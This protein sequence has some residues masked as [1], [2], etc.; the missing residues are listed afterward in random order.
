MNKCKKISDKIL[1]VKMHKEPTDPKFKT[2]T[3]LVT[4]RGCKNTKFKQINKS[5]NLNIHV[6]YSIKAG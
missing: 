2:P 3:V 6:A 4:V 5:V 1:N